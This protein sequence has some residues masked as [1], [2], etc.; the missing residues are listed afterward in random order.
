MHSLSQ[1]FYMEAK[2]GPLEKGLKT[3]GIKWGEIFQNSQVHPFWPQRNE[4]ILE[5][6]EA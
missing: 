6:S 5:K 4:D 2:F 3:I 1:F